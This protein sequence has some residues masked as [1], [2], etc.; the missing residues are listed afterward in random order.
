MR[1]AIL[2]EVYNA[3]LIQL[4]PNTGKQQIP[5]RADK[6]KWCKFHRNYD[7]TTKDCTTLKDQIECLVREGLPDKYIAWQHRSRSRDSNIRKRR[8]R[9]YS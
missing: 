8:P 6:N 3:R 4:P 7:H 5:L 1:E 2:E 9:R